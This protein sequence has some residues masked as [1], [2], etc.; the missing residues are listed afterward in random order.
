ME[1]KVIHDI[2]DDFSPIPVLGSLARQCVMPIF[3]RKNGEYIPLGTGF[4]ISSG[5]LMMSARHVIEQ[6]Q[7]FK[8]RRIGDNGQYY[9][10]FELYAVYQTDEK[11]T[12][13][14]T[15]YIGGLLPIDKAWFNESFDICA[16]AVG[17]LK[18]NVPVIFPALPLS[19]SLPKV[20]V[21]V[22][23]MGYHSSTAQI[24]SNTPERLNIT[25]K[26]ESGLTRGRIVEVFPISRDRGM[27]N[28]PCFQTDARFEGGMSGG[29]IINEAGHVVGVICSSL[30]PTEED[31]TYISYGSLI[32][33]VLLTEVQGLDDNG[34]L[35]TVTLYD[36]IVRGHIITDTSINDIMIGADASGR[37][38]ISI[39]RS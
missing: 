30:P 6:A 28:F 19:P 39:R 38:Q 27:L 10:H 32:W 26:Q 18:N 24:T 4:I 23:G 33:P 21:N 5:G 31:P 25:Y 15:T 3:G 35:E 17:I 7:S 34:Q 20:G 1:H 13:D 8:E 11:N 36:L 29:P 16:F 37:K 22:L 2:K 12:D 14:P 9:D